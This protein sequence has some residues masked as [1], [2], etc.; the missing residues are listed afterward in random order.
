MKTHIIQLDSHD[1]VISIR[2]KMSWAKTERILLIFPRRL[3]VLSR[4]LDLRLLHRHAAGLGAQ[5]AIVARSTELRRVAQEVGLPVFT[6]AAM[7]QREVW[8]MEDA[9]AGPQRRTPPPDLRQ[10]REQAFPPE[11][12]WRSNLALRIA[13]F[14]I[15]ILAILA[16]LTLFIPSATIQL[17]PATRLQSLTFAVSADPQAAAVNLAGII[18]ARSVSA[19]A[20][21]KGTLQVSGTAVL[22]DASASGTVRF[23]NQTIALV[24]IPA[25]TVVSTQT[26]PP[27]RFTTTSNAVVEAGVDKTVDVPVQA[28]LGG[29][30]GNL[31]P[32]SLVAIEGDLGASLAVTNPEATMGGTD[33]SAAIQTASDRVRLRSSLLAGLLEECRT[34]LPQMIAPGD[35]FF[36][37]TVSV[38]QVFE[39]SYFP[40]EGQPG[41]LLSLTL[42]I[43]CQAQFAA[44]ADLESLASM[45]LD[46]ILP[47]GFAPIPGGQVAVANATGPIVGAD[48]IVRWR[49]QAQRL[50]QAQ[51]DALTVVQ[52][53]PGLKPAEAAQCLSEALPLADTPVI[54]ETPSWWPWLPLLPF[55]IHLITNE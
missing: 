48:G 49:I 9:P 29:T 24:S 12:R 32:D 15:G 33:R 5:L 38:A 8:D 37:H 40:A 22:P 17:T 2:D 55:R 34:T 50:L 21:R 25:G 44:A 53:V 10:M 7:A 47:G 46:A 4:S 43:Q 1:D 20:E 28:V 39:E 13:F 36:D 54:Q 19:V 11:P 6:T 23:R 18:P 3:R 51:T 41:E 26:S 30:S 35:V 27:V 52:L 14:V 45:T 16:L 31:T 42:N